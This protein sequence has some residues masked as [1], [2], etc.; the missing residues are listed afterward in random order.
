MKEKVEKLLDL[1][2]NEELFRR[3][4]DEYIKQ[5]G[6]QMKDDQEMFEEF[7]CLIVNEFKYDIFREASVNNYI[8]IYNEKEI[9][10]MINYYD[11]EIGQLIIEKNGEMISRSMLLG[12]KIGKLILG[13]ID[14]YIGKR[15]DQN[16]QGFNVN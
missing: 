1:T 5:I 6:S 3:M 9:D 15:H 2:G 7:M 13:K 16:Q 14:D 8:E 12:Q 10:Y 11:S 4:R